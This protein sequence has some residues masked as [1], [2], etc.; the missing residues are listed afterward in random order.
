MN[1]LL[2]LLASVTF[3]FGILAFYKNEV[4]K[5]NDMNEESEEPTPKELFSYIWKNKHYL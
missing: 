1:F 2:A 5:D 3:G 4:A